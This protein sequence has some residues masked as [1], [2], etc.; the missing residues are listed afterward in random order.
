MVS[1][2]QKFDSNFLTGRCLKACVTANIK[3]QQDVYHLWDAH[4]Y[5]LINSPQCCSHNITKITNKFRGVHHQL[6]AR[7]CVACVRSLTLR[8]DLKETGVGGSD[9][10]IGPRP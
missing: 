7:W 2:A 3:P 10:L 4:Y 5:N 6:L 9:K 8:D 1:K